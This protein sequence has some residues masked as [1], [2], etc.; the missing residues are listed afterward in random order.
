[1]KLSKK[2]LFMIIY[3]CMWGIF[4]IVGVAI[5]QKRGTDDNFTVGFQVVFTI[6][7]AV[8]ILIPKIREFVI[9]KIINKL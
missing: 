9:E 3:C 2:D 6:F 8:W 5:S 4:G 7:T 1:M